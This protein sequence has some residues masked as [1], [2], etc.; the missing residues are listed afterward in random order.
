MAAAIR[1]RCWKV[2]VQSAG[3]PLVA[4]LLEVDAGHESM[5]DVDLVIYD[6]NIHALSPRIHLFRRASGLLPVLP[7]YEWNIDNGMGP[8]ILL[9]SHANFSYAKEGLRL[10]CFDYLVQPAPYLEIEEALARAAM[11]VQLNAPEKV[12]TSTSSSLT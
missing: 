11:Q 6:Q 12:M 9:T 8:G 2:R 10:G 5:D 1:K 3:Y 4:Q 7:P